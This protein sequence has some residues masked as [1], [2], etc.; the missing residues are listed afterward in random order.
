MVAICLLQK[1]KST[2]NFEA[3]KLYTSDNQVVYSQSLISINLK[4][5]SSGGIKKNTKSAPK[6]NSKE[7][8]QVSSQRK[9]SKKCWSKSLN[10]TRRI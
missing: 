5:M 8:S 6:K 7:D 4:K 2:S 10:H 1:H 9:K 3:E